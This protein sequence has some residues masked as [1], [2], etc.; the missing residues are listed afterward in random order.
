VSHIEQV[1]FEIDDR[2]KFIFFSFR[3]EEYMRFVDFWGKEEVV[4]LDKALEIFKA[5]KKRRAK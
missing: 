2:C 3:G 5:E 4:T 1:T